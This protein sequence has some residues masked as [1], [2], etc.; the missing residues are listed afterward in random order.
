[1]FRTLLYLSLLESSLCGSFQYVAVGELGTAPLQFGV[2]QGS[3]LGLI[4]VYTSSFVSLLEAMI[5]PTTFMSMIYNSYV[6]IANVED[7]KD[8]KMFEVG[9]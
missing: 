4:I 3:I 1:M 2:Q 5:L 8:R 7:N 6:R 9:H